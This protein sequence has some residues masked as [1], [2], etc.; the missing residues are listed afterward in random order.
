GKSPNSSTGDLYWL[1]CL[2]ISHWRPPGYAE[3]E[4]RPILDEPFI[5]LLHTQRLIKALN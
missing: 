2:A 5:P 4:L 1:R 3:E